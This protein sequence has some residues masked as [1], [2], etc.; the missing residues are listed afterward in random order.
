[1][2]R[3]EDVA[4]E[5]VAVDEAR[6]GV[7]HRLEPLQAELQHRGQFLAALALVTGLLGIRSLDLRNASHA[8]MTR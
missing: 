2:P 8:A 7:A 5:P 3:C 4:A 6:R 1:M